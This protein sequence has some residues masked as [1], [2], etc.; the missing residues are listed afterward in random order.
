M[1]KNVV[2]HSPS[3]LRTLWTDFAI[4]SL[5]SPLGPCYLLQFGHHMKIHHLLKNPYFRWQVQAHSIKLDAV[6]NSL[7]TGVQQWRIARTLGRHKPNA[8]TIGC[9]IRVCSSL[10]K[11]VREHA[12]FLQHFQGVVV[13]YQMSSGPR[14]EDGLNR[15]QCIACWDRIGTLWHKAKPGP[16]IGLPQLPGR[17]TVIWRVTADSL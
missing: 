10:Y 1:T 17:A 14:C 4:P 3:K 13:S 8:A 15:T 9:H 5:H 6:E 11:F 12:S 16:R 7:C 2:G